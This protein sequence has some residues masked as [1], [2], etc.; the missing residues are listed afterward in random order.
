MKQ[1]KCNKTNI[2]LLNII[3]TTERRDGS[4]FCSDQ[5]LSQ[6]LRPKQKKEDLI[7]FKM[8]NKLMN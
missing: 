1:I 7:I 5:T 6:E 3:S 8:M 4:K 2:I